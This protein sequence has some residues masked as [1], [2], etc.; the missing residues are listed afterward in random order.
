MFNSN[1]SHLTAEEKTVG[2]DSSPEELI[3]LTGINRVY[4]TEAGEFYALRDLDLVI[5]KGELLAI[6]GKSGSGKTTLLNLIA[7]IDRPSS[8]DILVKG[9]AVNNLTENKM[10]AWRGKNIG[11]VFQFFQLFPTLTVLEN[12]LLAMDFCKIIPFSQREARALKLLAEVDILDQD[13]KLPA[14]L[15]GGQQ[16]RAA[17]ARAMANDPD[18]I[19]A[20]EPTGNLDSE[21][22]GIIF[23]LLEKMKALG[24]TVVVVSHDPDL[25]GLADRTIRLR[26]GQIEEEVKNV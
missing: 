11:V 24:K 13:N 10:A 1:L 4:E 23:E 25:A 6:I 2:M 12:I 26:D 7:G 21:A 18:I 3:R 16:Q 22:A 14:A 8:G 15:S 9:T 19:V 5:R 17:F 20:D